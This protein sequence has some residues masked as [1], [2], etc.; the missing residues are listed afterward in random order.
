MIN[1]IKRCFGIQ[2][3]DAKISMKRYNTPYD[4]ETGK[5]IKVYYIIN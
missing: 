1:W 3:E 2:K 5:P 4:L